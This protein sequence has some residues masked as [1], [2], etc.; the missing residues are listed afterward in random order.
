MKPKKSMKPTNPL[1]AAVTAIALVGPVRAATI[2]D[3]PLN[4]LTDP[5]ITASQTAFSGSFSVDKVFDNDLSS[6]YATT[7]AAGDAFINFDF[8]SATAIGGFAFAQRGGSGWV[9]DFDLVFS[10]NSDFS[11]PVTTLNFATSGSPDYT[12]IYTNV[13]TIQ[14]IEFT[15]AVTARYVRWDSN[16]SNNN[17][18]GAAEMQFWA[19]VPEPGS[20]ALMGLGGLCLLMRRRRD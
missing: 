18:D 14:Q 16:A 3:N 13:S 19:P 12:L 8:G 15:S 11:A 1:L 20:A 9:T 17:Y 10:N 4:E 6:S 7:G 5:T 2:F